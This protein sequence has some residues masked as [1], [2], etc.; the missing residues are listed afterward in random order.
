MAP[1][2]VGFEHMT[3]RQKNIAELK[4]NLLQPIPAGSAKKSVEKIPKSEEIF[5]NKTKNKLEF[6]CTP[7]IVSKT[8]SL[9]V[10]LEQMESRS[11]LLKMA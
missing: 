8:R 9:R 2:E 11:L 1:V 5:P 6:I 7:K 4:K 3:E 10:D